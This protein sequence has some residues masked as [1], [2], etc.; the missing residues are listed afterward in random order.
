MPASRC[1][2]PVQQHRCVLQLSSSVTA[3]AQCCQ[4]GKCSRVVVSR[5]VIGAQS[6][7]LVAFLSGRIFQ[8]LRAH[9]LGPGQGPGLKRGLSWECAGFEQLKPAELILP[10]QLFFFQ[11]YSFCGP[12]WSYHKQPFYVL[13][14]WTVTFS[15]PTSN[16]QVCSDLRT[17]LC[18]AVS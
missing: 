17:Y 12:L 5:V 4:S 2:R 13:H 6:H 10:A 16:R 7:R 1:P 3:C 18:F 14:I 11:I 8:G 15:S 9:F